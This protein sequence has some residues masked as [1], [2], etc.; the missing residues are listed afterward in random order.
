VLGSQLLDKSLHAAGQSSAGGSGDELLPST[1]E[2]MFVD[3]NDNPEVIADGTISGGPPCK[4]IFEVLISESLDT[5]LA[6]LQACIYSGL[7]CRQRHTQS[8][9]TRFAPDMQDGL[10]AN[11]SMLYDPG[12]EITLLAPSEAAFQKQGFN[13]SALPDANVTIELS[14]IWVLS[15][16]I[17][18]A[19]DGSKKFMVPS[20]RGHNVTFSGSLNETDVAANGTTARI[21]QA[22][23]ACKS[24]VH[25]IDSILGLKIVEMLGNDTQPF[26]NATGVVST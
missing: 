9:L 16:P 18:A 24:W 19:P 7:L 2:V 14:E 5:A 25:L 10:G 3:P 1:D 11:F 23:P 4:S 6:V 8:C 22:I 26:Q 21:I 15:R 20:I 17:S 12:S 13:D